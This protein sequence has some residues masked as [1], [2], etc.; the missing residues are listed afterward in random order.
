MNSIS[1]LRSYLDGLD[2]DSEVDPSKLTQLLSE[3]WEEF[4]GSDEGGMEAYKLHGR[5]EDPIWEPPVLTFTIERHG[6]AAM[7]SIRA[8]LQSWD[9]DL[10]SRTAR[11]GTCGHREIS[12]RNPPIRVAPIAEQIVAS[13]LGGKQDER[14][15]WRADGSA[16]VQTGMLFPQKMLGGSQSVIE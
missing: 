11:C 4:K 3:A 8:E 12:P 9:L 10:D 1:E 14:I 13:I 16:E 5:V 6:A 7:G 15:K 2:R